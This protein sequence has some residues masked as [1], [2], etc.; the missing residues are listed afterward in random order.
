MKKKSIFVF[1]LAALTV[2]LALAFFVSPH[3]SSWPDGLEKIAEKLGFLHKA[4]ETGAWTKAPA[5]DYALPAI[6]NE[7]LSTSIA[8]VAGTLAVFAAG[9]GLAILLKKRGAKQTAPPETDEP[10]T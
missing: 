9:W 5:P 4:S 8:G 7:R 1:I 3:A 6:K 10:R 2:S